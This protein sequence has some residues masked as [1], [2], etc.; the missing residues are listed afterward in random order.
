MARRTLRKGP[1]LVV[2]A[3]TSS[4]WRTGGGSGVTVGRMKR[5]QPA[6]PATASTAKTPPNQIAIFRTRYSVAGA[7]RPLV[8]GDER[9]GADAGASADEVAVDS[10]EMLSRNASGFSSA[11]AGP[12]AAGGVDTGSGTEGAGA[13]G[14]G[15]G[16]LL[17]LEPLAGV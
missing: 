6:T 8:E 2:S 3:E 14:A 9:G 11:S 16:V 17:A 12:G 13:A 5:N 4:G 7:D 10:S 15:A 1:F